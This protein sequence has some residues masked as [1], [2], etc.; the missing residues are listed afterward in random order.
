MGALADGDLNDPHCGPAHEPTCWHGGRFAISADQEA[1][2]RRPTPVMSAS[3]AIRC[4]TPPGT[5]WAIVAPGAML[6]PRSRRSAELQL[7][8]ERAEAASRAKSEFLANM[9]HELRTPLNAIIG[10]SE[11]IRDQ[12]FGRIGAN[13]V[14][15]ATDINAA[16]HHLLDM[17]NDVLDLS[18]IEAGRY[19]LADEIVE[20]AWWCGPASACCG[21]VRTTA[22]C[23]STT[24]LAGMRVAVRGDAPRAEAD[25]AQSA[26]QRREV[27]AA[28]RRGLAAYRTFRG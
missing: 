11:L 1:R 22:A 10:F 24:R 15:Y 8:K 16:G 12:P 3:T 27:H 17:I 25:R 13:Y 21:R 23:G 6:P 20:L 9:S 7:A 18:K 4:S 14:E 5:S 2:P 28:G 26:V 19:E